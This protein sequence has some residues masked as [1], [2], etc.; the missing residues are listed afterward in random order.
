MDSIHT[1]LNAKIDSILERF[2]TIMVTPSSPS[3][4][5]PP[6]PLPVHQPHMKL[7]VPRFDGHDP[8]GWIFK[9][10][11]FFDY[12]AILEHERLTIA[13][14][15]MDGPA[16]SWFQWMSRNGYFPSWPAMLQALES[17][18]APSYYDDPQGTLFKLRQTGTVTEYLTEFESLANRT[19]GLT[20][21][22]LLSCFVSGLILELRREVQ[23]LCPMSL[24]QV[25]ELARLQEDKMLDHRS[26][27]YS[28]SSSSLTPPKPQAPSANPTPRLPVKRL[29][30]EELAFRRDQGLCYHCDDK[31]SPGHRCR[32]RLH[33]FIANEDFNFSSD[34]LD[35]P[36]NV[37]PE[38]VLVP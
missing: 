7:E 34:F 14:F 35:S 5:Q 20:P 37:V 22:C 12:Q 9:I 30:A 21:S 38:P 11:Q 1:A 17:R 18:F 23:A 13:A 2:T 10:S 3:S 31:W 26:S 24:L 6:P 28:Y 32:M 27:H 36:L 15:Y 33:L 29:T 25:T 16:L 19:F 4:L 8:L